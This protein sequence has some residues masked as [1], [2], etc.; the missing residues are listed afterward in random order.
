M[1]R[2]AA[3]LCSAAILASIPGLPPWARNR[4]SPSSWRWGYQG[5]ASMDRKMDGQ[6]RMYRRRE[7][8]DGRCRQIADGG[9][10]A[11]A[12]DVRASGTRRR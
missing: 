1:R 7:S 6:G 5:A 10:C 2:I 3:I 11:A 4:Q 8:A 9:R 12:G